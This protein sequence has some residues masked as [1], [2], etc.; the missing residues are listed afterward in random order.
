MIY[1][2]RTAALHGDRLR[3]E[4]MDMLYKLI[5]N[6]VEAHYGDGNIDEMK[7]ELLRVLALDFDIE[8]ELFANLGEDGVADRIMETAENFYNRK[9]EALALPFLNSIKKIAESDQENKPEKVFVDFS[10]GRRLL[11]VTLK[12]DEIVDVII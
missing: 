6:I 7:E 9:R 4:L 2:R 12:I 10:D 8:K 5:Q 1:D 3:G 11:R